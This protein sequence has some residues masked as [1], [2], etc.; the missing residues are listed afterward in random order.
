MAWQTLGE[1][2]GREVAYLT[3]PPWSFSSWA[4]L[5]SLVEKDVSEVS[6][7][8]LLGQTSTRRQGG[9]NKVGLNKILRDKDFRKV[10]SYQLSHA[11]SKLPV[12]AAISFLFTYVIY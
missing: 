10:N 11:S 6:N 9:D 7:R 5:S 1:E 3:L 4:D 8:E 12:C 2:D